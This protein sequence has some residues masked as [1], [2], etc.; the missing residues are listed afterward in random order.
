MT[1]R[2]DRC[3]RPDWTSGR[4]T[5]TRGVVA[6]L[7]T[8]L[9]AA[10][11]TQQPGTSSG[12]GG[13]GDGGQ[14]AGGSGQVQQSDVTVDTPA[15]RRLKRSA[16]VQTC[17]RPT[18]SARSADSGGLPALTLPC[19]GGGPAVDLARLRGPMVINLF[20]QWCGPCR[21]ELPYYERLHQAAGGRVG[22]LGVD[23]LDTLPQ[24][25][26]ELV[27]QT[28][29]T[30]PLLADPGGLLRTEFGIR[31]LP[32]VVF[33]DAAG[34]LRGP[35]MFVEIRSYAQLRGLVRSRL[36]IDLPAAG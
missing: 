8:V 4:R 28:G 11:S 26:L 21:A 32:G 35:V 33:V 9:L 17:P 14:A 31:A 13:Q 23:Y 5:A 10:C 24:A 25:A 22:V 7:L 3:T 12:G 27:K 6:L 29:V 2:P 30:Y 15:L 34:K 20:A 18:G 16:S 19:L 1:R 36:G